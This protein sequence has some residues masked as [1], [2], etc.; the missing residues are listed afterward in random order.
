MLAR[1]II[2][3]VVRSLAAIFIVVTLVFLV[4]RLTGDPVRSVVPQN[5]PPETVDHYRKLF[6][7]D[8]P[9]WRQYIDYLRG[10][11]HGDFGAS[12]F[13]A[14]G[15]R[16]VVMQRIPA[17]LQIDIPA[18]VLSTTFGLVLGIFAASRS[19]SR[20]DRAISSTAIGFASVPN[21]LL[22]VVLILVLGVRLRWLPTAGNESISSTVMPVLTM[23]IPAA[24]IL[25]RVTRASMVE[26][27]TLPCIAHASAIHV[28]H[29]RRVFA[30]ALPNAA[31][32]ILTIVG[33]DLAYLIAGSAV[34]EVLLSW[35]GVGNLFIQ[36]SEQ[37]DYAVV[38]CIVVIITIGV[39]TIHALTDV[40][41][42]L[43]DP[44]LRSS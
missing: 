39:V 30:H 33:F 5:A 21:F 4:V 38:E 22:G 31:R 12:Y 42:R 14:N 23:A 10:L 2:T 9:L 24:A 32:P 19:G 40:A 13:D 43:V 44:R 29:R 3:R 36:A 7:L 35:P 17:T 25:A 34:V 37:K 16:N 1:A 11:L 15:A 6:G 28:S 8:A 26:A 41:Y 18:F 20:L 27:L